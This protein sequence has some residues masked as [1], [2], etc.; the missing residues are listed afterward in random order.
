M[1][2]VL[3]SKSMFKASIGKGKRPARSGP[4]LLSSRRTTNMSIFSVLG[5]SSKPAR[6]DGPAKSALK[7]KESVVGK[8]PSTVGKAG[9][10]RRTGSSLSKKS[11][12]GE[13]VVKQVRGERARDTL[14]LAR[15]GRE[16]KGRGPAKAG[17]P[18]RLSSF[19]AGGPHPLTRHQVAFTLPVEEKKT[20]SMRARSAAVRGVRKVKSFH[21]DF[22]GL[23]V[24]YE[25][26]K[27][28]R[29]S[30]PLPGGGPG[31]PGELSP[32]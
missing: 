5:G 3:K 16:G 2:T 7:K 13:A 32:A 19:V 8:A 4:G 23:L 27:P 28:R 1:R 11:S 29:A 21:E 17:S 12:S 20:L 26:G 31:E 14:P 22:I 6:S 30:P 10:M 9:S 24:A 25:V 18:F 15:S